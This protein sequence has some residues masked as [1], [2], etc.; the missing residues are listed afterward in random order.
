MLQTRTDVKSGP[1][2]RCRII[3][4]YILFTV[5]LVI[6]ALVAGDRFSQIHFLT[7]AWFATAIVGIG[8][9]GFIVKLIS[10]KL[11]NKII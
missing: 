4:S 7:P 3:R 10:W 2:H 5:M 8:L 1:C 9:V 11:F 6:L